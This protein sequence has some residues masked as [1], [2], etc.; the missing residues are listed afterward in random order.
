[1][2]FIWWDQNGV[3]YY[4]LLKPSET[5]IGE[6]YRLQ[7]I[8]LKRPESENNHAK[9]ILQYDNTRPHVYSVVKNYLEGANWEV[10][11]HPPYSPDIAPSD[12]HLF[13]SMQSPLSGERFSSAENLQIWIDNWVASKDQEFFFC[14]IF[15]LYF[16]TITS[17][18]C[19]ETI[20]NIND[21]S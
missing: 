19:C 18:V 21:I 13:L 14:G 1:M 17:K 11:S 20:K 9:I 5:I 12:Y 4:E 15:Y 2:L 10:L 8:R 3:I 7:I 16:L 6:R